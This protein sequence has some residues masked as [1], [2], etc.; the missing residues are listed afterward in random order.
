M[1]MAFGRRIVVVA[2]AVSLAIGLAACGTETGRRAAGR[3]GASPS[4]GKSAAAGS[5]VRLTTASF[6]PAA[7][8]A[9]AHK[10]SVRTS[11]R[12]EVAG[13]TITA[14]GVARFGEHPAMSMVMSSPAFAGE[15]RV[16]LVNDTIYL[17]IPGQ[18]PDGKYVK[19]DAHADD[20]VAKSFQQSLNGMNPSTTF[21]A[22]EAGLR[23]VTYVKSETLDGIKVQ[24][25][26]VTVDTKAA[27]KAQGQST[28][29][30]GLPK[31]ITY[32]IWLD[33]YR[34][35]RKVTFSLAGVTA[36]LTAKDYGKPVTIKA[37]PAA[38]VI[39]R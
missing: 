12:M 2:A 32:D 20:P 8:K 10:N 6:L 13:Q 25:Y 23:K 30:S 36:V 29:V 3:G 33:G 7:K 18:V 28:V 27:L 9:F 19:V 35:M 1:V 11:M 24:R 21:A 31:T 14:S 15:A 38:D 34:L 39:T 4:P 26:R 17:S 5:P 37:P 22:F 16:I